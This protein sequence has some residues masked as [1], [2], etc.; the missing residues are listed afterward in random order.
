MLEDL[1]RQVFAMLYMRDELPEDFEEAEEA[2]KLIYPA[3]KPK[4]GIREYV[5]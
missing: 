1:A 5:R 3:Y 2:F 4:N